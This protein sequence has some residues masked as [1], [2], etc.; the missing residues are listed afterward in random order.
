MGAAVGWGV[1][2]SAKTYLLLM[3]QM[4]EDCDQDGRNLDEIAAALGGEIDGK[5]IRCPSPGKPPDDRSMFVIVPQSGGR[6]F[7]YYCEGSWGAAYAMLRQKLDLVE[8]PRAPDRSA[9]VNRIWG[10]TVPAKGTLVETYLRSRAITMPVP[11]AI[12]FHEN[13]WHPGSRQTWPA[14]VAAR[15]SVDGTLVAIHRTYLRSDGLGKAPVVPARMDLGPTKGT[16]IRLSSLSDDLVIGEGI[17]T[18]LSIVQDQKRPG[19]AAGSAVTLRFLELPPEVRKVTFLVDGDD[20][21][22]AATQ[23]A[24][25]KLVGKLRVFTAKA[26]PGKDFNDLLMEEA[27]KGVKQ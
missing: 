5:L 26:P 12:R 16:A 2:V 14:M 7:I 1:A 23:A 9:A 8:A 11:D 19:W 21:G 24:V 20:A 17:E 4:G 13:L 6:P 27:R 25:K 3:R 22:R 18:T 15:T 10:E